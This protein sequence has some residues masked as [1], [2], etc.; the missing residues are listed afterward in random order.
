MQ[1][2]QQA[3]GLTSW[4]TLP[5]MLTTTVTWRKHAS[6]TKTWPWLQKSTALLD[7]ISRHGQLVSS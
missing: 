1:R 3:G 4:I 2:L 5:L 6:C 7:H